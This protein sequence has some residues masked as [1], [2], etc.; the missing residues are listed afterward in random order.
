[1]D[2]IVITGVGIYDGSYDVDFTRDFTNREL[3]TIKK[4][5]GVT[6]GEIQEAFERGD[7]DMVV[8]LAVIALE[9]TGEKVNVDA[10]WD[11]PAGGITVE[12]GER[13][14]VDADPLPSPPSDDGS[15]N[16][17]GGGSESSGS[18]SS[19]SGDPLESNLSLTGSLG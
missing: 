4:V 15:E 11:A 9:R 18:G 8:A 19:G 16:A 13:D 6:A 12:I 7:N 14:E 3:H 1:M 17:S 5:A 2:K 10:I